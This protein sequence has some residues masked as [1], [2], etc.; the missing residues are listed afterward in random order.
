[1]I[2]AVGGWLL[3]TAGLAFKVARADENPR[4][5]TAVLGCHRAGPNDPPPTTCIFF[6]PDEAAFVE[7]AVSRLI[8]ADERWGGAL[9]AGVP[10]YIDS[11]WPA[12]GAQANDS[13]EAV[14]GSKVRLNR[15]ISC[16]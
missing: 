6:N 11:S 14:H 13:T 8:P 7:A 5:A 12:P 15:A 4:T 10:N 9:E 3:T 2:K 16:L 1:M